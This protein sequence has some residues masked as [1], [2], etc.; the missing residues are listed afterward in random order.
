MHAALSFLG[1]IDPEEEFV[2]RQIHP[3]PFQPEDIDPDK[4]VV[5]F[6]R[7]SDTLLIH[8]FGRGRQSVSVPV[9]K[10][11]YVMVDPTSEMIIGIHIEGFLGQAIKDTPEAINLLDYAELRGITLAEVRELRR[12]TLQGG[13]RHAA[14]S[15]A[16][17][18]KSIP[19]QRKEAV[20][21]FIDDERSHWNLPFVPAL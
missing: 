15:P 20:A 11:L 18:G 14:N 5:S 10:Y 4:V 9:A 19:E 7:P 2:P 6:D 16:N 21:S 8:L 1:S 12:A 13:R 17:N 3:K